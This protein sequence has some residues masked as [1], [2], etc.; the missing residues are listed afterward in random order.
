[1]ANLRQILG[2]TAAD[3]RNRI[4]G[5]P[6]GLVAAKTTTGYAP[7][8]NSPPP[9]H[10]YFGPPGSNYGDPYGPPVQKPPPRWEPPP[11]RIGGGGLSGA[12]FDTSQ[13]FILAAHQDAT[14]TLLHGRGYQLSGLDHHLTKAGSSETGTITPTPTSTSPSPSHPPHGAP[15]WEGPPLRAG[16]HFH[17]PAT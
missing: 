17:P 11:F 14:N 8:G 5:G 15:H 13:D 16:P 3:I 10:N 12:Q 7:A 4:T 6:P 9:P 2:A 1:M